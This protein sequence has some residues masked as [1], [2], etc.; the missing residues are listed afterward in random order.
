M[1]ALPTAYTDMT[2]KIENHI[3]DDSW[4]P[5]HGTIIIPPAAVDPSE[6]DVVTTADN[7]TP[8]MQKQ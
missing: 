8:V 6:S 4:G 1:P 5:C 2:R 3:T 7:D